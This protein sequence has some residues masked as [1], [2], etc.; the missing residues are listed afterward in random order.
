MELASTIKLY[1]KDK[2]NV[3]VIDQVSVPLELTVGKDV[4]KVLQKLAEKNGIKFKTSSS[5][6][7]I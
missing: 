3:N 4:G 6:T 2:I 5:I 1:L 7:K